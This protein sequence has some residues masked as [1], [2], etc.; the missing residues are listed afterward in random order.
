MAWSCGQYF[1]YKPT[2]AV[3]LPVTGRTDK[4]S[5]ASG[6]KDALWKVTMFP[7]VLKTLP[8]RQQGRADF[9]TDCSERMDPLLQ[10]NLCTLK[11]R[12]LNVFVVCTGSCLPSF[13]SRSVLHHILRP[14][15]TS[16]L[17][18]VMIWLTSVMVFASPF[19]DLQLLVLTHKHTQIAHNKTANGFYFCRLGR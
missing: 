10:Q 7:P 12:W 11:A 3:I 13:S 15:T 5:P 18:S 14:S 17:L 16:L 19:P 8:E 4:L 6:F 9:S 1:L 2:R